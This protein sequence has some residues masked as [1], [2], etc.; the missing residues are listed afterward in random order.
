MGGCGRELT[1]NNNTSTDPMSP[2]SDESKHH[3]HVDSFSRVDVEF[4]L[5]LQFLSLLL[6]VGMLVF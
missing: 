2:S 1:G 6:F 5:T 3:E 4:I